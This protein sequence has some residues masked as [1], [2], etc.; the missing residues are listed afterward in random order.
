ME[1]KIPSSI[2]TRT[3]SNKGFLYHRSLLSAFRLRDALAPLLDEVDYLSNVQT[4]ASQLVELED[5]TFPSGAGGTGGI[6]T[7]PTP[8][9]RLWADSR[10]SMMRLTLASNS[11]SP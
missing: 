10:A 8:L 1:N 6:M 7:P 4:L 2:L 5:G 9:P 3:C 11:S